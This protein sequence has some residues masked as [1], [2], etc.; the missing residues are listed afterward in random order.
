MKKLLETLNR[1]SEQANIANFISALGIKEENGMESINN[2]FNDLETRSYNIE[3][4]N[5]SDRT[6]F[7]QDMNKVL[8]A[9]VE[10]FG[11]EILE[12][13]DPDEDEE[14]DDDEE[15]DDEDDYDDEEFDDEDDEDF[16]DED[17]EDYDDED[18]EF[19]DEEEE[20]KACAHGCRH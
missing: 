11:E 13:V 8:T 19:D 12:T 6:Q 2:F 10:T 15:F 3:D 16:D 7:A 14:L 17:D 1:N 4:M 9:L 5:D 20:E 18:E